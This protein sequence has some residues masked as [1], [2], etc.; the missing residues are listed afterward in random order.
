MFQLSD[1]FQVRQNH[2]AMFTPHS[3]GAEICENIHACEKRIKDYHIIHFVKEGKGYLTINHETFL[4]E[5]NM[6]FLIPAGILASYKA[7]KE[8]PWSYCWMAFFCS[9]E[10]LEWILNE[11]ESY[12]YKNL[13]V[14]KIWMTILQLLQKIPSFDNFSPLEFSTRRFHLYDNIEPEI[15]F[16]MSATLYQIIAEFPVRKKKKISTSREIERVREYLE[17]HCTKAIRIGDVAKI[18]Y[19]SPTYLTMVFRKNYKMSPKE[20]LMTKK[21]EKA[22]ELLHSTNQ[23]VK[24][25]AYQVGYENQLEFSKMF[26]KHTGKSPTEYRNL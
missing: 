25:I 1:F 4:I 16:L 14:E 2:R 15:S 19:M 22:C 24:E 26:K 13:N 12:I 5:E 10:E 7:D 17:V 23:T 21:I 18:F 11:S 8:K 9:E 3:F 20:Y 6:A